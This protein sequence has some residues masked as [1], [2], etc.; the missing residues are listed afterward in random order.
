MAEKGI[1]PLTGL[2]ADVEKF[3]EYISYSYT[4][5]EKKIEIFVC[6]GCNPEFSSENQ[7][8]F[9]GFIVNGIWPERAVIIKNGCEKMSLSNS[10]TIDL[11]DFLKTHFYPKKPNEKSDFLLNLLYNKQYFDESVLKLNE[12]ISEKLIIKGYFKHEEEL[13]F[14]LRSLDK[15][16]LIKYVLGE[17]IEAYSVVGLTLD[18]LQKIIDLNEDG[19]NSKSCFIAM[20]FDKEMK[21]C[22][23]AIK[24]ALIRANYKPDLIDEK[25]INSDKTIPDAILNSIR[26]SKFCIADFSQ[27]KNGVYFEAGYALGLG[28]P[29]IYC[30]HEDEFNKSHFDIKQ[31]QHIIYKDEAEL[32]E[33]LFQKIEAWIK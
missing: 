9:K 20:S 16:N 30:C 18:G 24:R 26:N 13:N 11:N 4:F 7:H 28:K 33:K 25:N 17:D 23:D 15:R 29:V 6:N 21:P 1:C 31:L 14:Y 22:R 8:I 12:E 3:Q 5:F 19:V 32:E 10:D 2:N 27:H